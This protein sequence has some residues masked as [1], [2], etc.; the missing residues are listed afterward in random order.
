MTNEMQQSAC[1]KSVRAEDADAKCWAC[2]EQLKEGQ[3][4]CT[5]CSNWQG[6]IRSKLNFSNALLSL[7]AA[8]LAVFGSAAS[9]VVEAIREAPE[10]SLYVF[11]ELSDD[12]RQLNLTVENLN[13]FD[14]ILPFLFECVPFGAVAGEHDRSMRFFNTSPT[15]VRRLNIIEISY[16]VD[17]KTQLPSGYH[18]SSETLSGLRCK[19]GL[20]G[21]DADYQLDVTFNNEQ[22]IRFSLDDN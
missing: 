16:K 15:L 22:S 18:V 3:V 1:G 19:G 11:G 9:S 14:R 10:P 4:F 13:E 20:G 12:W 8:F 5:K 2:R 7:F 17:P 21:N 6:W